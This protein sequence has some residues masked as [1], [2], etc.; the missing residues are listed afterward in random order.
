MFQIWHA[1][2]NLSPAY[3]EPLHMFIHQ[4]GRE[5]WTKMWS[6]HFFWDTLIDFW[7]E[8]HI[9]GMRNIDKF[10]ENDREVVLVQYK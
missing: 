9:F 8:F 2:V 3:L 5:I 7:R 10:V 6:A 4:L 1:Y